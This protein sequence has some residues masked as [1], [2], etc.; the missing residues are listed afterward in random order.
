LDAPKLTPMADA[1]AALA[2]VGRNADGDLVLRSQESR[3]FPEEVVEVPLSTRWSQVEG[4]AEIGA[5]DVEVPD[6][7]VVTLV[8]TKTT[9]DPSDDDE[10]VLTENGAPY[11][12]MRRPIKDTPT[13]TSRSRS[14]SK[15]SHSKTLP[16]R[17][18]SVDVLRPSTEL[19]ARMEERGGRK[20][21]SARAMPRFRLRVDPS[22]PLPVEMA[23]WDAQTNGNDVVLS[24]TTASETNNAGFVVQ[25]Q[26]VAGADTTL[27]PDKW[28]DVTFVDG[29]GTRTVPKS[30]RYTESGLRVG[31]HAFRLRQVDTDG[32]STPTRSV[33]V[34]VNLAEAY[35]VSAPHPNPARSSTTLEVAV[36]ENQE[37]SVD[38]YDVLGRRV[39]R[40]FDTKVEAQQ[41]QQIR[42][43]TDRWASGAYFVRVEGADFREV[44]RLTIVR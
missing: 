35:Q 33:K 40:V 11:R 3:P 16:P 42:I 12:F 44:R 1:Y 7:W 8:D 4:R 39:A 18:P 29:G 25:H 13:D 38:I 20:A 9:R 27:D 23:Q 30:Y 32:S 17:P 43:P 14:A 19:A 26:R 10:H 28:T 22:S 24:W 31:T 21:D 36:R 6:G 41:V 34:T 5:R 2:P 37:V 15:S